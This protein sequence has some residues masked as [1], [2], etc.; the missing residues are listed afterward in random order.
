MAL[1]IPSGNRS[2]KAR[3][4]PIVTKRYKT[5]VWQTRVVVLGEECKKIRQ[6]GAPENVEIDTTIGGRDR[7]GC[8]RRR[9]DTSEKVNRGQ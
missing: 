2:L 4:A 1:F 3:N 5:R 7:K 6:T 9:A 8:V